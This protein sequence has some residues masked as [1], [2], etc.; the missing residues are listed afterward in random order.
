METIQILNKRK[1]EIDSEILKIINNGKVRRKETRYNEIID[2]IFET[3]KEI[4]KLPNHRTM[5]YKEKRFNLQETL[6]SL[7]SEARKIDGY[8][9]N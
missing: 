8:F 3:M 9:N 2:K 6:T 7:Q 5:Y 4:D 1:Q